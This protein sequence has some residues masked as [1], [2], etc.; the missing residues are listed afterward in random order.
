ME[1][2]EW[3]EMRIVQHERKALQTLLNGL[4]KL[5]DNFRESETAGSQAYDLYLS[6]AEQARELTCRLNARLADCINY[7]TERGTK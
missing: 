5:A 1:N 2:Q 7:P 3:S 4:D 6:M